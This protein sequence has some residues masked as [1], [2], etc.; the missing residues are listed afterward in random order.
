LHV[1]L[2]VQAGRLSTPHAGTMLLR[3]PE[4]VPLMLMVPL[5]ERLS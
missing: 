4:R 3:Q 5:S 1:Q 2:P